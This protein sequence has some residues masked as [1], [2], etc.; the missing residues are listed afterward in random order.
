MRVGRMG[1][2]SSD[3]PQFRTAENISSR[4]GSRITPNCSSFP[5]AKPVVVTFGASWCEPCREEYPLLVDALADRNDSFD[6]VAVKEQDLDT[7]MRSLMRET[8]ATWPVAD[9]DSG[10]IA[11]K[12]G[13]KGLPATF[14]IRKSGVLASCG[15]GITDRSEL[16]RHLDALTAT[17]A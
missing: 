17:N 13:I 3:A 14:F 16:N 8:G 5:R 6:I 10:A 15:F 9:D 4:V 1:A 2:P 7:A 12:Y 11:R